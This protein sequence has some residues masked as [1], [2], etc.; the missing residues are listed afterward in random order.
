MPLFEEILSHSCVLEFYL[1]VV[2]LQAGKLS[3]G[4]PFALSVL[5]L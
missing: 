3:N 4:A 1:I 2:Q 5:F